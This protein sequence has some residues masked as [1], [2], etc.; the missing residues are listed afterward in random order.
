M[1]LINSPK[2]KKWLPQKNSVLLSNDASRCLLDLLLGSIEEWMIMRV[3]L[4][5]GWTDWQW[6]SELLL[7][8]ILAFISWVFVEGDIMI[9]NTAPYISF[10]HLTCNNYNL[11]KNLF[12]LWIITFSWELKSYCYSFLPLKLLLWLQI[13]NEFFMPIKYLLKS[14]P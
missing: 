13:S 5:N 12:W 6:R 2:D 11:R 4:T 3:F 9:D 1:T 10:L 14:C 7:W 8:I